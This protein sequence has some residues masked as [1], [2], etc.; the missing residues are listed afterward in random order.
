[1]GAVWPV[2][3]VSRG[4]GRINMRT[5]RH[6]GVVF[7]LAFAASAAA[8]A[9]VSGGGIEIE[10][11]L[12][13]VTPHGAT[14]AAGYMTVTNHGS[15]TDRLVGGASPRAGRVEIHEMAVVDGTMVMR[16]LDEGAIVEPGE[17]LVLAPDGIHLMFMDMEYGFVVGEEIAVR[18]DFQ[19]AG[20]VDVVFQ[21]VSLEELPTGANSPAHGN[22]HH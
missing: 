12:T 13:H 14:S 8:A 5:Y 6:L 4:R 18:L 1:M 9:D 21:A 15:E 7:G 11:P 3:P 16:L 2:S 19:K 17:S 10:R 22:A 20:E